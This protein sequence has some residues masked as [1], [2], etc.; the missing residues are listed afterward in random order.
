MAGLPERARVV[1]IGAGIVGNSMAWHLAR[2]GWRDIV[3]LEKGTL[4]EPRRLDRPRLQLHLPDRPLEGDDR[5]HARLRAPVR[6]ARR[7]HEDR[8][9]RGR[10]H[11]GAD[12]GAHAARSRRSKSWGIEPAELITPARVKELVPFINED[13]VLG[14]VYWPSVG[15][16]DSLEA[17]T[18]MR[19]KAQELGALTIGAGRRGHR[20]STSRTAASSASARTSGDIEAET[21][22]IACGVWSPRIAAMAGASIPL[23]PAVHQMIDIGPVRD[24]RARRRVAVGY[25]IIRDVDTNMYERQHGNEFEVGSYAHRRDPHGPRRHPVDRR[26]GALA[27]D[28]AVHPGGLR[29][30][31]RGRARALPRGRRRREGRREARDQR[32]A[33]AHARTATRSS[34][35]RRRSRAS[36]RAA[37]IWIKEAPGIAEGDRRVDDQRRARDRPARLGHRPVLRPPQDREAHRRPDDRG[38]QQDLRHR[39]PDGAVGL[40]PRRPALAVLRAREGARRRVLRGRRLGAAVLVRLERARCSPSSATGSCRA[41]PSGNRAGGRRSSTPSTSRCATAPGSSTSSAFAIFDV[42]GPGAA[43]YLERLCV[44]KVDVAPRARRSTRRSST[45]PAGSSPT[46]RSCGSPTTGSAS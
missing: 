18:L 8:R 32:P 29:P 26:V 19:K 30:P 16:V 5:V 14:G 33:L 10:P 25:P 21:V 42:T 28:A 31:A 44:N 20:A 3:L 45:A 2:L 15:V 11:A 12:A 40:E 34:A 37:A 38:L 27:D 4:P 36:G 9:H 41:R 22:V 46:S 6:G 24:L 35:R 43:A 1:V 23:T 39:P 17:G 13:I 7:V